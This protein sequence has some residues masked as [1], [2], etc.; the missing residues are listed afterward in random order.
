MN[1]ISEKIEKYLN[2]VNA[3]KQWAVKHHFERG[4]KWTNYDKKEDNTSDDPIQNR[5]QISKTDDP[6]NSRVMHIKD[7]KEI[8]RDKMH[9]SKIPAYLQKHGVDVMP[10]YM[11]KHLQK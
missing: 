3:D 10:K 4:Q 2:E 5:I 8:Y 9:H 11:Q 1:P 6:E 7:G